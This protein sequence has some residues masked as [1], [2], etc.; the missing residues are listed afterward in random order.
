[1]EK[2]KKW[3]HRHRFTPLLRSSATS[4]SSSSSTMTSIPS[5]K[6]FITSVIQCRICQKQGKEE[7]QHNVNWPLIASFSLPSILL[8][9]VVT[10]S[11]GRSDNTWST[12]FLGFIVLISVRRSQDG[13]KT[14]QKS[15]D[16]R[17]GEMLMPVNQI[18]QIYQLRRVCWNHFSFFSI[19]FSWFWFNLLPSATITIN[20]S[21]FMG[22]RMVYVSR[23]SEIIHRN[24][25]LVSRSRSP[26]PSGRRSNLL[27]FRKRCKPG[28]NGLI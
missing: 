3:F 11:P 5:T 17:A 8:N 28:L 14:H 4:S 12:T 1:M 20:I 15:Y 18:N 27:K 26:E 13:K 24:T 19:I 21:F 23:S 7:E 9:G 22:F 6:V 25:S 2:K 16:E 10:S